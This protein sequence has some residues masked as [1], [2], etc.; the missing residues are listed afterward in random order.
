ME[1][2]AFEYLL[3]PVELDD[4]LDTLRRAAAQRA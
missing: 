1:L 2:G 3:K 4:L